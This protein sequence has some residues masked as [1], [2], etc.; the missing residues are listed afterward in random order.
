MSS[1]LI[2]LSGIVGGVPG[3][4]YLELARQQLLSLS[5]PAYRAKTGAA[6][7]S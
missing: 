1:A 2:E 4:Q 6:T 3:Q 7:S 5:S